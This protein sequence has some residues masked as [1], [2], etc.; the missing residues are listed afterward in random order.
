MVTTNLFDDRYFKV[1][2]HLQEYAIS[3]GLK[4]DICTTY[5]IVENKE[6]KFYYM[7]F[8][9]ELMEIFEFW[10]FEHDVKFYNK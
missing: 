3:K 8:S 9:D 2:T 1:A 7:E 5:R 4:C 6:T 10:T